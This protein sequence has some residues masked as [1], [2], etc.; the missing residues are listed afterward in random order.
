MMDLSR[1]VLALWTK[2]EVNIN[3]YLD[4]L[5]ERSPILGILALQVWSAKDSSYVK[6]RSFHMG[7]SRKSPVDNIDLSYP[8][9]ASS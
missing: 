2:R 1:P 9:I 5:K 4:S 7:E 3:E 6:T 8:G